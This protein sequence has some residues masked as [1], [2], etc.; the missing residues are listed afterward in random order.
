MT[1]ILVFRWLAR[2]WYIFAGIFLACAIWFGGYTSAATRY[3]LIIATQANEAGEREATALEAAQKAHD[4]KAA[5][6]STIDQSYTSAIRSKQNE[7]NH[8]RDSL[9]SGAV[10]VRVA[11][12]CP[13][14]ATATN[15]GAPDA[16]APELDAA[17]GQAYLDLRFGIGEQYETI[18]ALQAILSAERQ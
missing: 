7:I 3:Q 1:S 11:A 14:Q 9:K 10:R 4:E 6:I 15:T 17:A 16:A 13:V 12:S 2:R 8:L 5:A 18:K